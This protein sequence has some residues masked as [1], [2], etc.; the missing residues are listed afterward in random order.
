MLYLQVER[1][2]DAAHYL[3]GYNGPCS[4]LHGHTWK[5][6]VQIKYEST[7]NGIAIDFKDIKKAIDSVLPDHL[8]LNDIVDFEKNNPTAEN[9]SEYFAKRLIES[10]LYDIIK[11][12]VWESDTACAVWCVG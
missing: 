4:N 12:E 11:V 9:L 3:R 7:Y 10:T 6:V 1:K 8:C 5:V 2:F